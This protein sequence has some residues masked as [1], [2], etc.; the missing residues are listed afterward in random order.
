MESLRQSSTGYKTIE[1]G[2]RI[3]EWGLYLNLVDCVQK[4]NTGKINIRIHRDI[5][6]EIWFGVG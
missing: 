1:C 2:V 4:F 3:A 6:S 5:T